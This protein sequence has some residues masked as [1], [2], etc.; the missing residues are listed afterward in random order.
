MN[1]EILGTI[2][3]TLCQLA[4]LVRYSGPVCLTHHEADSAL[5]ICVLLLFEVSPS[6]L[7]KDIQQCLFMN[8]GNHLHIKGFT[9]NRVFLR[10]SQGCSAL[11]FSFLAQT[12]AW[13]SRRA[14][15]G[16]RPGLQRPHVS[17]SRCLQVHPTCLCKWE[18][19]GRS[20]VSI[21]AVVFVP[22]LQD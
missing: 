21:A 8:T 16:S 2:K 13:R 10:R 17:S 22:E 4:A 12:C 14:A 5:S 19:S 1:L 6:N 7:D 18:I 3:S 15:G 11:P 9:G 20:K